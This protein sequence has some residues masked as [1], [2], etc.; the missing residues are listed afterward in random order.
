MN[1]NKA[2]QPLKNETI[3]IGTV[4]DMNENLTQY[5]GVDK[6]GKAKFVAMSEEQVKKWAENHPEDGI[7]EI[8]DSNGRRFSLSESLHLFD[9]REFEENSRSFELEMLYESVKTT[10]S[11]QQKNDLARFVRKAKTAEEINTYMTG[12]LAQNQMNE[13]LNISA[14]S[15]LRRIPKSLSNYMHTGRGKEMDAR[16][17]EATIEDTMYDDDGNYLGILDAD[18]ICR[19][20]NA[21]KNFLYKVKPF[22]STENNV[23]IIATDY[24]GNEDIISITKELNE[25]LSENYEQR[26]EFIKDATYNLEDDLNDINVW[27]D[28]IWYDGQD[29]TITVFVSNGDW[30]H[31]HLK[32]DYFLRDWIE[33]NNLNAEVRTRDIESDSDVYDAY[34]TIKFRGLTEDLTE[35]R[36]KVAIPYKDK[37]ITMFINHCLERFETFGDETDAELELPKDLDTDDFWYELED[38]CDDNG[39]SFDLREKED[40]PNSDVMYLY[41]NIYKEDLRESYISQKDPAETRFSNGPLKDFDPYKFMKQV[42]NSG[43]S[44]NSVRQCGNDYY[45][46]FVSYMKHFGPKGID[47]LSTLYELDIIKEDPNGDQ[48]VELRERNLEWTDVAEKLS[49]WQEDK[50]LVDAMR[51]NAAM[52]Y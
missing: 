30:K 51:K 27:I 40:I 15:K 44:L 43:Q 22:K 21:D 34:H 5:Y 12:M 7:V 3:E 9:K 42:M 33:K 50:C 17:L 25:T 29:G 19:E 4:E 45:T 26:L 46:I 23:R 2:R 31:D 10:L 47:D 32:L 49:N 35:A 6:Y 14:Y 13:G 24:N 20:L 41:F 18:K 38:A 1:N 11:A 28:D 36:S 39:I 52:P 48:T 8:E 16:F 37:I